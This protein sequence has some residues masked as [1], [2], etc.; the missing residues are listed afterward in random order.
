CI[1]DYVIHLDLI[2]VHGG[3]DPKRVPSNEQVGPGCRSKAG[4]AL[5]PEIPRVERAALKVKH[6]VVLGNQVQG[7]SPA[8]HSRKFGDHAIRVRDGMKD[9]A[10]HGQV[11]TTV[12]RLKLE[13][14]LVLER[15]S[16]REVC[17]A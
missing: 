14:T 13:N 6:A 9:M 7:T 15:Q 11:E 8:R 1:H 17:V 4:R 3:K 5:M 10:A 12:G 16:G 2:E